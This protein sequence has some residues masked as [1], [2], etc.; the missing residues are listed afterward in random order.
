[1]VQFFSDRQAVLFLPAPSIFAKLKQ[2]HRI[3]TRYDELVQTILGFIK[4]QASGSGPDMRQSRKKGD[5]S[6]AAIA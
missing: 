2:L 1:M 5:G 4:P 3:A 6:R